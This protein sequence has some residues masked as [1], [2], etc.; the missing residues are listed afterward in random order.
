MRY[1]LVRDIFRDKNK[2]IDSEINVAGWIRTKRDSKTFGF[3]E[4]ND[5]SYFNNLQ[6]VFDNDLDNFNE[7]VKYT[8][9]SSIVVKGSLIETPNMK[10]PFELKALE[11]KLE[12]MSDLDYPL[13][14]KRHTFEYLRTIAHLRPRTNAFS[15]VF[16]LRSVAAYAIHKFFQEKGFVYVNTPIITGSD[17][18]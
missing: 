16:R 8:T 9:G 13:Q 4:L 10:Q 14:K 18:E 17:C 6:V 12:G 1:V 15:A 7:I 2:Y 5:G 3:I 11:I